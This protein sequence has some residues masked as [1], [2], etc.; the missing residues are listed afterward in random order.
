MPAISPTLR[1]ALPATA[2]N[3]LPSGAYLL[4]GYSRSKLVAKVA[5]SVRWYN[6]DSSWRMFKLSGV[7]SSLVS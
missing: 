5:K 7:R 6:L 3:P 4:T 2:E 1:K